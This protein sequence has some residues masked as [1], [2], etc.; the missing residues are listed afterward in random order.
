[1][2]EGPARSTRVVVSVHEGTCGISATP[3]QRG[4]WVRIKVAGHYGWVAE[5]NLR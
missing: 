3:F 5:A 1:V 4:R 2:H